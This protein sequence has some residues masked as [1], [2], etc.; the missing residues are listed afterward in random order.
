MAEKS[1]LSSI[2]AQERAQII[3]ELTFH[4]DTKQVCTQKLI[5]DDSG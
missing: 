5:W 4:L 1:G 2:E 3:S